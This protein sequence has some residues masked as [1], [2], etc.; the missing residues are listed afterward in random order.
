[1][2]CFR[3][4]A[5]CPRMDL[6]D[7]GKYFAAQVPV[8]ALKSPLLRYSAAAIAAKQLGRVK[9]NKPI[10]GGICKRQASTETYPNCDRTNWF[11]IATK[12]YN[13][14][15]K[16]LREGLVDVSSQN[17]S[18][19]LLLNTDENASQQVRLMQEQR[20]SAQADDLLASTSIL[21][22]YEFM[23]D[24]S[25]EWS[26]SVCTRF[27]ANIIW[28]NYFQ[29]FEWCEV[30]PRRSKCECNAAMRQTFQSS[31]CHFL[32]FCALWL[33]CS[34]HQSH[35]NKTWY[36]RHIPVEICRPCDRWERN[37]C[38]WKSRL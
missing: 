8:R 5:N 26:R 27:K 14:A 4:A 38:T 28:S 9:G 7:L 30:T 34:I 19:S 36:G 3:A 33:H 13:K 11:Y 17:Y 29:A 20:H 32:E 15:I 21:S 25:V 12:Y 35:I 24:S 23:D 37:Y 31:S 18:H 16:F 1:M 22:V 6:Y 10:F 2:G